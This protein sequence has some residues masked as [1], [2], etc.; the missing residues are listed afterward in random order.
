LHTRTV[1]DFEAA[2]T[3]LAYGESLRRRRRRRDARAQLSPA[4][5]AFELLG[6]EGR[7]EQAAVELAAAGETV[8]RRGA[9]PIT[10]LTPQERQIAQLLAGGQTTRQAAAQLFLSPKTVEYHLRHVYTKLGVRSRVELV[11]LFAVVDS[12]A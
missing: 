9:G 10:A 6:A 5:A 4:L 2:R 3:R 11:D 8:R 7:A 12:S 1:D